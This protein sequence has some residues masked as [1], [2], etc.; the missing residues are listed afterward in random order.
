MG[1][2]SYCGFANLLL[3]KTI[4]LALRS[5]INL[6]VRNWI[7]RNDAIMSEI[8]CFLKVESVIKDNQI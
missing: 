7:N 3:G 4:S 6:R 8:D 1:I 5:T 2:F